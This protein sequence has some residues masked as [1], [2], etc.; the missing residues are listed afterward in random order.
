M[1]TESQPLLTLD[2]A[3]VCAALKGDEGYR[4]FPYRDTC[5]VLT[6]GYGFNLQSDGLTPE[7]ADAV[8]ALR[9]QHRY[10]SLLAA[11]PWVRALDEVRQAVLLN[12][13]YNLGVAG[14]QLFHNMLLATQAGDYGPAADE[15][16][17]SV[18][19]Q[20]VGARAARLAAMMRRGVW[21][22]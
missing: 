4:Q 10:E 12:M 19:A 6:I 15:M 1:S 8:L 17:N 14:L 22:N 21:H 20:Q 3:K 11:L 13:A 9:V 7:E 16:L 2:T 5:G 18:W